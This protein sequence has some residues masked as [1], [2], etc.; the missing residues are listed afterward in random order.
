MLVFFQASVCLFA[1]ALSLLRAAMY[2]TK[3]MHNYYIKPSHDTLPFNSIHNPA[4]HFLQCPTFRPCGLRAVLL[5]KTNAEKVR[6]AHSFSHCFPLLPTNTTSYTIQR[7]ISMS[8]TGLSNAISNITALPSLSKC[9]LLLGNRP[10][11]FHSF[12]SFVYIQNAPFAHGD[13]QT[14]LDRYTTSQF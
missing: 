9:S 13:Y 3:G 14:K 12:T 10:S 5:Q 4:S 1:L 7:L 11:L 8:S 2:R 6:R